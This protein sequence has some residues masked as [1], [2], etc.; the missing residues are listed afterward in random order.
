MFEIEQRRGEIFEHSMRLG[1]K[2]RQYYQE[3][4]LKKH[5]RYDREIKDRW[6][7]R[8]FK[9]SEINLKA[10]N[11][12]DNVFKTLQMQEFPV[13]LRDFKVLKL[14]GSGA[15]GD[16]YKVVH[17]KSGRI[18]ALKSINK[19][20]VINAK[21]EESPKLEVKILSLKLDFAVHLH[22]AFQNQRYLYI[23]EDYCHNG[24]LETLLMLE[25]LTDFQ[26]KL[27]LAQI[28]LGLQNL[29][30]LGFI[31]RDLKPENVLIDS[32]QCIRLADF[33]LAGENINSKKHHTN[34]FCGTPYYIS[35]E[36]IQHRK[37]YKASD[38]FAL[39]I[40]MYQMIV[41]Y[42]PFCGNTK[43]ELYNNIL[44]QEISFPPGEIEESAED[45]IRLLTAKDYK[46]RLGFE[47][48][49]EIKAH[50]YFDE[51]DWD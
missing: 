30:A 12:I 9:I 45:L 22:F 33:G 31:Y 37:G 15:F 35:P 27:I 19:Q 26:I 50:P 6:S 20:N 36:M 21:I 5:P 13:Q 51:I 16:V 29:H 24:D 17:R 32:Q 8:M 14:L 34:T 46:K 1:E 44:H 2:Y 7:K 4:I 38:Y 23:V 47:D 40:L 49:L 10:Q 42:P 48:I 39:G 43:E 11:T 3:F 25:V 18:L 41:G 28:I